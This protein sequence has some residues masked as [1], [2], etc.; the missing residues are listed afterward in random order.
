MIIFIIWRLWNFEKNFF[1]S[2]MSF[3]GRHQ[4]HMEVPRLGA[5]SE[6][7]L[8]AYATATAMWDPSHICNLY[9]S[10]RQCQIVNPLREAR[11]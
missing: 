8:L 6:L 5:K 2:F 7:Q 4:W 3:L 1:W 9:N 11:D 10:S